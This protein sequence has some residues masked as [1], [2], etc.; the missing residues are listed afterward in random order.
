MEHNFYR[1][2]RDMVSLLLLPYEYQSSMHYSPHA[3]SINRHPTIVA[4]RVPITF[5]AS[6]MLSWTLGPI[7]T[8]LPHPITF[9]CPFHL[10]AT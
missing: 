5:I 7:A 6:I 3:F 9:Y 10:I 4:T 1:Y 2:G 8:S